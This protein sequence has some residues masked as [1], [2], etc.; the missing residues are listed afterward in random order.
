MK[1]P[2]GLIIISSLTL[3]MS[4]FLLMLALLYALTRTDAPIYVFIFTLIGVA[5]LVIGIGLFRLKNWARII[6]IIMLSLAMIENVVSTIFFHKGHYVTPIEMWSTV[7]RFIVAAIIIV[8][9][10]R[11]NIKDIFLK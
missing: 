1:K 8:Y 3:I 9:L 10:L 7:F 6:S 4:I 2:M 5:Y 11:K